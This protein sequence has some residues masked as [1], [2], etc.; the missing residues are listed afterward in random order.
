[1]PGVK[2]LL[3]RLSSSGHL[4]A[5]YTGDS[6]AVAKKV[7]AA[8]R[9][10][11]YFKF[12]FFGTD[13]PTRADMVRLAIVNAEKLTGHTFRGKDIVIIGDSIRDVECGQ[14]FHAR[15]IAVATGFH[16]VAE[17]LEYRPDYIFQSLK[18]YRKV[19]EAIDKPGQE[20]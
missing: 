16:T 4:L 12:S 14:Q 10:G 18:D 13:V 11:Q 17:L 1:L 9:L 5:L 2:R 8:T 20:I 7:L 19:L 6:A 15:T 3:T